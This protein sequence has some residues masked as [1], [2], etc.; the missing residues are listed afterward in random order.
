MGQV[1]S[2]SSSRRDKTHGLGGVSTGNV[3]RCGPGGWRCSVR[4]WRRGFWR[5]AARAQRPSSRC[6]PFVEGPGCPRGTRHGGFILV[7]GGLPEAPL[8]TPSRRGVEFPV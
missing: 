2:S 4:P 1:V 3:R 8:P 6:V 7:T 5:G